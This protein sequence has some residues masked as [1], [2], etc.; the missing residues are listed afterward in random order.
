MTSHEVF[1]RGVSYEHQN[2]KSL[3]SSSLNC[4]SLLWFPRGVSYE[5]QNEKSLLSSSPNCGSLLWFHLLSA[6]VFGK[7]DGS[8]VT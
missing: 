1:P 7:F 8:R 5:H 4:G 2:E 3:L 6:K